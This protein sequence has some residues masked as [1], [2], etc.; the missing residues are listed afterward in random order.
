GAQMRCV[1]LADVLEKIAAEHS[2]HFFDASS[3]TEASAIDGIHLDEHQ[4]QTLGQAIADV[5][6]AR[7]VL[8][9]AKSSK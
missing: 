2:T 7:A 1:G 9:P 3:V 6:A 8:S 5:V 4:H